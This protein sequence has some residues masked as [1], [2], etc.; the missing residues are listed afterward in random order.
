MGCDKIVIDMHAG[1]FELCCL[2][3]VSVNLRHERYIYVYMCEM[4]F[5]VDVAIEDFN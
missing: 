5:V 1:L 3:T 4:Q 2:K